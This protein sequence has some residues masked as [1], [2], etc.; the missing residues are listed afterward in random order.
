MLESLGSCVWDG[1]S[2]WQITQQMSNFIVVSLQSWRR[3]TPVNGEFLKKLPA[4]E[5][6]LDTREVEV[7]AQPRTNGK[8]QFP[9]GALGVKN[10][11]V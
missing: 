11:G 8:G 10:I 3:A 9:A 5:L 7:V 6:L 1:L 4:H 2:R